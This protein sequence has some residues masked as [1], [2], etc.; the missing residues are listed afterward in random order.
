MTFHFTLVD[1]ASS[2]AETVSYF[3]KGRKI[4]YPFHSALW[5]YGIYMQL[6]YIDPLLN[7]VYSLRG[8][9]R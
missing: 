5:H 1:S 9:S 7:N 8:F 6:L 2:L 3:E 4:F